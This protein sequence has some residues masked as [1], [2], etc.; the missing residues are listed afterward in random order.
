MQRPRSASEVVGSIPQA[1]VITLIAL[2]LAGVIN[3]SWWWVLSPLWIGGAAGRR[4]GYLVVPG[5]LAGPLG[6]PV[7]L[8][9]AQA[10]AF[11]LTLRGVPVPSAYPNR[12]E[13][14][15]IGR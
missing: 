3:W 11:V 6:N 4:S 14:T 5:S 13:T 15:D 2:K 7:S 1:A 12:A 10:S 9:K 8:A